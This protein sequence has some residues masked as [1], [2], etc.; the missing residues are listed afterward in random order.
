MKGNYAGKSHMH[1]P[2]KGKGSYDRKKVKKRVR[3]IR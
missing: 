3:S 2:K 1:R